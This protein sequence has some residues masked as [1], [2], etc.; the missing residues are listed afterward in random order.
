MTRPPLESVLVVGTGL[1][2]TSIGLALRSRGIRVHLVDSDPATARLAADLGAGQDGP[3]P[4]PV[5]LAVLAVPPARIAGVLAGL[6]AAGAAAAYTDVASVKELP[7]TDAAGQGCDLTSYVGGHP[8]AGRER[9]GPTAARGDLF[10]G[11]PWVLTPTRTATE[12][13]VATVEQL[14]LACGALPVQ[15]D[16][17]A[18][19]QAMALVSHAPHVMASLMAARLAQASESAV[20]LCGQGVRDVT[21]VAAGDPALWTDILVSNAHAV[22]D[23]LEAVA[24]DLTNTVRSLRAGVDPAA[25]ADLTDVL[26]RGSTG[27]ARIPGKHNTPPTRYVVVPVIIGDRAGELSRLFGDVGEAKVNIEDLAIEHSPG[28]PVGLVELSVSPDQAGL[29]VEEL[30]ARGW[31]VQR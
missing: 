11:R 28:Q 25:S 2:G 13:A 26:T 21:R 7:I 24:A 16:P 23:V 12:T 8:M 22:A 5:D 6:Q 31:T 19:D 10:E 3:P 29:L 30:R 20:Q 14:V 15:M 4:H 9:S 18:H 1:I 17:S 27:Q